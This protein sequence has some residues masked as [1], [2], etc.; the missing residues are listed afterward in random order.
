MSLQLRRRSLVGRLAK[1]IVQ[2][3]ETRVTLIGIIRSVIT[4][5]SLPILI[6]FGSNLGG[7]FVMD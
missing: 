2:I 3:S 5:A 4:D 1:K 6:S 7:M